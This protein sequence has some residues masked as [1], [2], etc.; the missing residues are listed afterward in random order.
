M[1]GLVF[2]LC[3]AISSPVRSQSVDADQSRVAGLGFIGRMVADLD[4]SVAFYKAIGFSQDPAANPA[5]RKDE[6]VEKL[7]GVENVETRMAR[8]F[9]NS[10]ASGERFVVYLRELKGLSRKN[11]SDHTAWEPGATHFGLVAADAQLVW[12]QLKADGMLRARSW[13]GELI[14]PPGQT[15]GGTPLRNKTLN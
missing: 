12:S 3:L 5:W 13:G 1:L 4:R 11:V 9:V 14:A 8:M 10:N 6:V 2:S 7:Y 15:R